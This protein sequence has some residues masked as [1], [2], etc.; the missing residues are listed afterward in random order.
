[1]LQDLVSPISDDNPVGTDVTYE[2][3]FSQLKAE[4]DKIAAVSVDGGVDYERVVELGVKVLSDLSKDLRAATFLAMGLQKTRGFEGLAE[5][6]AAIDLLTR[7]YW[8]DMYPPL[9]RIRGRKN[10]LQSLSDRLKEWVA[11]DQPVADDVPHLERALEHIKAL[12]AFTM[13]TMEENA[14]A[15]SGLSQAIEK[16]LRRAPKPEPE[17][18]DEG[19]DTADDAASQQQASSAAQQ[20]SSASARTSA[21]AD[22]SADLES[23]K[24]AR[25]AALEIADF[26]LEQDDSNPVAYR[27]TRMM[28]WSALQQEP[29]SENGQT[30]IPPP[31]SHRINFLENL[32]GQNKPANLVKQAEQSFRNSAL[33]LDLQRYVA[34]GLGAMGM[35]YAAAQEAVCIETGLLLKRI[36]RLPSLAFNDGTPF[37]NA[38]T[39]AWI[40]M[41]VEPLFQG[42]GGEGGSGGGDSAHLAEQ[43]DEARQHLGNGDL[44]AALDAMRNGQEQDASQKDRFLRRLY[45]ATLCVKGGQPAVARPVLEHL[46]QEIDAHDLEAW[47]P[48]LALEVWTNLHRCYTTLADDAK[49]EAAAQYRQQAQRVFDRLCQIDASHALSVI[50]S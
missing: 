13:E 25:N 16:A 20:A 28:R 27:L 17:P 50:R 12:Q 3:S 23:E 4:I 36:P 14:P 48:S 39:K 19:E 11:D 2:D 5:G 18:S 40:E 7:K 45:V 31:E 44:G 22:P 10:A 21:A 35:N 37:A 47:D 41:Q 43:Y 49:D 30:L 9:R 6:L 33:W 15:L 32:V 24:D 26:L 42:D 34:T 38:A 46:G 1:M 29:P 8:E